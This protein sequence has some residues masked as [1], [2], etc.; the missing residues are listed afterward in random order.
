MNSLAEMN[1]MLCKMS[2]ATCKLRT[3]PVFFRCSGEIVSHSFCF[4]EAHFDVGVCGVCVYYQGR[5]MAEEDPLMELILS[6]SAEEF[7]KHR[8]RKLCNRVSWPAY[9]EV[10]KRHRVRLDTCRPMRQM[11]L[12]LLHF[13]HKGFLN[14]PSPAIPLNCSSRLAADQI[15]VPDWDDAQD[16]HATGA[17][18]ET[19]MAAPAGSS[20]ETYMAA[21]PQRGAPDLAEGDTTPLLLTLGSFLLEIPSPGSFPPQEDSLPREIP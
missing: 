9:N 6:F 16:T 20:G 4:P 19:Y 18:G 10:W 14:R 5:D 1:C 2:I 12:E 13:K 17:S 3:E 11:E 15:P 8:D 7:R 21:P